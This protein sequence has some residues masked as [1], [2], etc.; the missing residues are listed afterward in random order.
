VIYSKCT[1][2]HR[3]NRTRKQSN[4]NNFEGWDPGEVD[5]V[6]RH[7]P[8]PP[9]LPSHFWADYYYLLQHIDS[10]ICTLFPCY[11]LYRVLP[12]EV[13]RF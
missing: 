5:W 11:V 2:S 10:L 1:L 8:P 9:P 7:R 4:L 6:P 13:S 3:S 12:V